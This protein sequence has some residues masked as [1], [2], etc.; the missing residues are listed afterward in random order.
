MGQ[1]MSR[2]EIQDQA[3]WSP[4]GEFIAAASLVNNLVTI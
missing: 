3:L 1:T 4:G 2:G